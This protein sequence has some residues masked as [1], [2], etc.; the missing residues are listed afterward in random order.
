[1][2]GSLR[3]AFGP[4]GSRLAQ[5]LCC[6]R[7]YTQV[8]PCCYATLT[9]TLG[10]ASFAELDFPVGSGRGIGLLAVADLAPAGGRPR[11]DPSN[12]PAGQQQ[13]SDRAKTAPSRG[14]SL[15]SGLGAV[16]PHLRARLGVSGGHL[17][18]GSQPGHAGRGPATAAGKDPAKTS[19]H[20][21]GLAHRANG[22][23]SGPA[24]LAGSRCLH[25]RDPGDSPPRLAAPPT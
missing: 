13:P 10:S 22:R 21:G 23:G 9:R 1:M 7:R 24:Q 20:S 6:P 25:C 18:F 2:S 5:M 4:K 3:S 8:T 19:D 12:N 14:D 16:E 17:R 11:T 15:S